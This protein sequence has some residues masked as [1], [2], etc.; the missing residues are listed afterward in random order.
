MKAMISAIWPVAV[1]SNNAVPT[2]T[3]F[4]GAD[5]RFE[6]AGYRQLTNTYDEVANF[7]VPT[8]QGV[9][10]YG[11]TEQELWAVNTHD[12]TLL[13]FAFDSTT[14][15]ERYATLVN[16]IALDFWEDDVVVLGGATNALAI[17][18]R[19]TGDVVR[20]VSLPGR[21]FHFVVDEDNRIVTS[22]AYM[23]GPGIKD[24]AAGIEK[25]VAE[26]LRMCS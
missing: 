20:V 5:E 21:P 1:G 14:P 11:T 7:N 17:H 25:L 18:D 13:R 15:A 2:A 8:T 10:I 3:S 23:L 26:A 19:T 24:V 4:F 22:P 6:I 16:P 12:S 9:A